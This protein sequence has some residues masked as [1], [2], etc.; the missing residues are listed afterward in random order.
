[1]GAL[2]T[3]R[4]VTGRRAKRF[5]R[6]VDSGSP[7]AHPGDRER[8]A[9]VAAL[10]A[11]E[12]VSSRPEFRT[13]LR[14]QLLAESL[15]TGLSRTATDIAPAIAPTAVSPVP[16]ATAPDAPAAPAPAP[17]ASPVRRPGY[18]VR[19][20]AQRGLFAWATASRT[21]AL[22][23]PTAGPRPVLLG[24]LAVSVVV[25]GITV[26]TH[27]AVPGEPLYGLKL[28]VEHI[29]LD[30][31]SS[32]V[33]K[34]KIH[35]DI[36]RTRLNEI[37]SIM[38]N[39]RLPK[40]TIEVHDLLTAWQQ[41]ASAGGNVLVT[42]AR[43]GSEDALRTVQDF[44]DD[45]SRDLHVLLDNLPDGPLH[46]MT[47][48]ALDYVHGV[49]STLST[50]ENTPPAAGAPGQAD[51]SH[52]PQP[53]PFAVLTPPVAASPAAHPSVSPSAA[54]PRPARSAGAVHSPQA[55]A[56]QASEPQAVPTDAPAPSA[57]APSAPESP[58]PADA[59]GP[60]QPVGTSTGGAA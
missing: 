4:R 20:P 60:V 18:L 36:A 37:N 38:D 15:T 27:R 56:T 32:P 5:D 52:S 43:R 48:E 29:Q 57:P 35:L 8:L 12:T 9:V 49:H 53:V 24:A 58:P 10:R 54:S 42:E 16:G 41:E 31:T 34:A 47:A 33:E 1:M 39:G 46:A 59:G 23:R 30:L 40:K 21:T 7:A 6:L 14:A 25:T 13:A 19:T 17:G 51:A 3:G 11:R 22:P 50:G 55:P 45:Q 2:L 26:G 44:T 28:R